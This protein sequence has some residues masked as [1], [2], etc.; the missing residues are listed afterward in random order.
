MKKK[1]AYNKLFRAKDL[2]WEV[3]E[4][5]LYEEHRK[6]VN[7]DKLAELDKLIEY[8]ETAADQPGAALARLEEE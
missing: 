5:I 7:V 8:V 3:L 6:E 2:L 1:Q 4:N